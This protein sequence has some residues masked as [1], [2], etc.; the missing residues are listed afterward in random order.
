LVGVRL[1]VVASGACLVW[2]QEGARHTSEMP[3][4]AL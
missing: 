1:S 3:K 2:A 4:L